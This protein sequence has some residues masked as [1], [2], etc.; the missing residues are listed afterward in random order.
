M[1]PAERSRKASSRIHV[2]GE[3]HEPD[4]ALL[5][6]LGH[7]R[8]ALPPPRELAALEDHGLH[9]R[10]PRALQRARLRLVG[11]DRDD[12]HRAAVRRGRVT[13]G[14]SCPRRRRARRPS[15]RPRSATIRSFGYTPPVERSRPAVSS[16]STRSRTSPAA[17]GRTRRSGRPSYACLRSDLRAP[18]AQDLD[19]PRTPDR[20]LRDRH[21]LDDRLVQVT[22]GDA[23]RRGAPRRDG[24]PPSRAAGSS[25]GAHTSQHGTAGSRRAASPKWRRI[26]R[27]GTRRPRRTPRSSG[28]GPSV[29]AARRRPTSTRRPRAPVERRLEPPA[30]TVHRRRRG[31]ITPARARWPTIAAH[32][33]GSSPARRPSRRLP[34]RSGRRAPR[35]SRSATRVDSSPRRPRRAG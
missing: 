2:A 31:R 10:R 17:G 6:P 28:T 5:E 13:P 25:S 18:A 32:P 23:L 34:S 7:R 19:R 29:R 12:L 24:P 21:D 15:C 4:V 33:L 11:A 1:R 14:G 30:Y 3:D 22:G 16:A 26:A 20:R 8:V 9:A 27:A 35:E